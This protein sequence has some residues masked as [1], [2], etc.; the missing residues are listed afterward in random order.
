MM[1]AQEGGPN[2][3]TDWVT[4]RYAWS[5]LSGRVRATYRAKVIR[6][7]PDGH[8][9][10]CRLIE[11]VEVNRTGSTEPITDDLLNGLIGK[12]AR[13]PHEVL[14]SDMILPL[15][16]ATLIG[17]LRRPYFFNDR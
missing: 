13:V 1:S 16:V 12:C 2:N 11:L 7:E 3:K 14:G 17:G 8:R 5:P 10:V 15:K 6:Y 9:D 4:L